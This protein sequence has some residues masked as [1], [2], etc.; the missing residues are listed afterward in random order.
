[1]K[2]Y[3]YYRTA[4]LQIEGEK[5][6]PFAATLNETKRE[7]KETNLRIF[8]ISFEKIKKWDKIRIK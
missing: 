2:E 1:M 5:E 8:R 7:L 3:D 4:V 6:N